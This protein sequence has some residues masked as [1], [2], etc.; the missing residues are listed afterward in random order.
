[1]LEM[2]FDGRSNNCTAMFGHFGSRIMLFAIP[3]GNVDHMHCNAMSNGQQ[4]GILPN[5]MEGTANSFSVPLLDLLDTN[6]Q[7]FSI[8]RS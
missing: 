5:V 3:N 6:A 8:D 1:M 4:R 7:L 2:L